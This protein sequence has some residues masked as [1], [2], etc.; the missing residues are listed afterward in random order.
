MSILGFFA[1]TYLAIQNY[2]GGTIAERS[3]EGYRFFMN[4]FSDLG[5][6][7]AW[8][9]TSNSISNGYFEA[10]MLIATVGISL[11]C[12]TLPVCLRFVPAKTLATAG[13]FLGLLAALSYYGISRN[14]LDVDYAMHTLYVRLGFVT[15]WLASSCNAIA[16]YR[17]PGYSR[18][19]VI[20]YVLFSLIL[21]VQLYIMF[22]TPRAWTSPA[23][24]RLQVTAQKAVVYS[25][26][27]CLAV[28]SIGAIRYLGKHQKP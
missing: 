27:L 8:N 18:H 9:G 2:P 4:Y 6:H 19:Y 3:T 26:L 12:I 15:F 25:Q 23:A 5:R 20:V 16:L 11:F 10:A 13:S 7:R 14:P 17:E 28:Q 1:L 21:L 22:F 24:L